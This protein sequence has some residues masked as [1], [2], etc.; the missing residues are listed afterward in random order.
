MNY[1]P[2]ANTIHKI[3]NDLYSGNNINY[4]ELGLNC[5]SNFA[6]LLI[7]NKTSVDI[8]YQQMKPTYLM[9]TDQF[10]ER[11][12]DKYDL[13]Y[14]DADHEYNQVIKDY[15]N[16]ND[17]ITKD[18][19]I[20]LHD[21]YPPNEDHTQPQLCYNSYKI[22]NYFIDNNYDILVNTD[23]YGA[24]AVFNSQKIDLLKFDHNIT[25]RQLTEK[26]ATNINLLKSYDM[27][28]QKYKE[29]IKK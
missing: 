8:N 19:I 3:I 4:L 25:Y 15:N 20:F 1:S 12:N 28:L 26:F 14:I 17:C 24:C 5:G 9:S 23:D 7:D 21:L 16:C 13:I 6:S 27:F 10:F 18:G 29:K 11:N 2:H 22:L